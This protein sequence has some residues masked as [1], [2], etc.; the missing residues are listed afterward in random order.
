M[1]RAAFTLLMLLAAPAV[2]Q[3]PVDRV[4]SGGTGVEVR[5]AVFERGIRLHRATQVVV[6]VMAEVP[7]TRRVSIDVGANY[8]STQ[9]ST[10]DGLMTDVAAFTDARLRAVYE[11]VPNALVVSL[12]A[13]L[14]TGK[15]Q[16]DDSQLAVVRSIAQNFFPFPVSSYGAGFGVTGAVAGARRFGEWNVG[17]AASAR[18]LGTYEPLADVPAEYSPGVEGRIR[19]AAQRAVGDRTRVQTA[20]TFSTF[21]TDAFVAPSTTSA[22]FEYRPGNRYIGELGVLHQVGRSTIRGIGWAMFRAAGSSVGAVGSESSESLYFG[23]VGWS[24]PVSSRASLEPGIDARFGRSADGERVR[25]VGLRVRSAIRPAS[26]VSLVGSVRMERG[27]IRVVGLGEAGVWG[28]RTSAFLR[29][30]R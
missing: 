9:L 17:V 5:T 20:F 7:I 10:F 25:L 16:I 19:L 4:A 8:V 12:A 6:P 1:M 29:V 13:N 24:V 21:G 15:S 2:A 26:R 22:S 14:P 18:Y 28:F 27:S 11:A 23:G 3:I 30:R